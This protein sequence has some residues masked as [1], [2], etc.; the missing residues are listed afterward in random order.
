MASTEEYLVFVEVKTRA[1]ETAYH[2][3]LAM[4]EAKKQRVRR[5]GDYYRAQHPEPPLQPRFDVLAV[6]L[7]RGQGKEA[8]VEHFINAF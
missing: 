5:L 4:T 7:R 3:T 6:T 1:Q 2:P 8:R